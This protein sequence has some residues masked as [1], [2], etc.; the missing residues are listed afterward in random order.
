M[1]GST[2]SLSGTGATKGRLS[3]EIAGK[4]FVHLAT[5]GYFA[6]PGIPSS[7]APEDPRMISRPFEGM[8][9]SSARGYFPGLLA[10]LVFSGANNPPRNPFSAAPDPS[11]GIMTAD[12]VAGLDLSSCELA[13][14][15]ACQTGLGKVAGGEGIL[16][17]QRAFHQA[18]ARTVVA[19][20][21][22]VD[23][24]ATQRLMSLFYAN[25]WQK[26]LGPPEAMRQAQLTLL[27]GEDTSGAPI[28]RGPGAVVKSA[29]REKAG[30]SPRPGPTALPR[31]WAGWVVS[32]NKGR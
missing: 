4:R 17:L 14:L 1:S 13:V 29:A 8:S 15:S 2:R 3:R 11:F 21:W 6:A 24:A 9:P 32:G 28:R 10:G 5:H 26:K 12:E 25:L 18:G 30:Q 7:L 19:S 22:T 23:D 20:L 27:R 16:S 31:L